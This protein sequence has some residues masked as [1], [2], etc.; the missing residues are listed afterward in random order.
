MTRGAYLLRSAKTARANPDA[1]LGIPRRAGTPLE[2][3]A[4]GTVEASLF[5]VCCSM[6]PHIYVAAATERATALVG[7]REDDAIAQVEDRLDL[8]LEVLVRAYPHFHFPPDRLHA[9]ER[10][11]PHRGRVPHGVLR[12]E[13][14]GRIEVTT[15][16]SFD[17]IAAQLSRIGRHGLV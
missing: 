3:T 7:R 16:S 12:V 17:G 4:A 6:Y 5:L 9:L 1:L 2:A 14:H 11:H 15:A 8:D 13:A 10:A